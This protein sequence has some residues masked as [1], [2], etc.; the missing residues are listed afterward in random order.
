[1]LDQSLVSGSSFR[2]DKNSPHGFSRSGS[3]SRNESDLLMKGGRVAIALTN[4]EIVPS[5]DAQSQ[6][7][8]VCRG[9]RAPQNRI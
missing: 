4:G 2:D 5:T 7:L 9:E 3:F 6:F 8:E 1:M